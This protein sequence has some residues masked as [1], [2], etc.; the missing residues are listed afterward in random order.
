[1]RFLFP[2]TR[3]LTSGARFSREDNISSSSLAKNSVVRGI[4]NAALEQMPALA[5]II[6][7]V[8]PKKANVYIVKW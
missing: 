1:M 6:D 2:F 3:A 5:S 4:R 7:V 8:M